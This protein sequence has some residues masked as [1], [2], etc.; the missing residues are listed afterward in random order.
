[1]PFTLDHIAIATT[2]L[3]RGTAET[4]A[5]LGVALAPGGQHARMGTHNRLLGLG[6]EYLE[7]I[8]IDPDAPAPDGPRWFDL[9]RFEGQ[10]RLTNWILRTDDLDAALAALPSG[11]GTPVQFTRGDLS[12]RMAVPNDGILPWDGLAPALIQWDSDL[13]PPA[14]L[15][16]AGCRLTAL[17]ITHPDV[18]SLAALFPLDRVTFAEGPPALSATLSTPSGEVVL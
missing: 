6:P 7:V 13:R 15:P 2:D 1:M 4:E 5:R 9:D 17:R 10:T 3:A 18:A 11:F 14:R 8:A 12:W 16:E